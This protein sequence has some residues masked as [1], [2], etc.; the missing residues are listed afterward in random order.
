[1]LMLPTL[2]KEYDVNVGAFIGDL[3]LDTM[4]LEDAIVE[5]F[6]VSTCFSY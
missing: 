6:E 3:L 4:V 5:D 2:L 1:M